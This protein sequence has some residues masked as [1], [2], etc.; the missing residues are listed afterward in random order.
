MA[1]EVPGFVSE[2]ID[3][4]VG[5]ARSLVVLIVLEAA[6]LLRLASLPGWLRETL[7]SA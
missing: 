6:Q 2:R 4:R 7:K 3:G 1:A 5:P